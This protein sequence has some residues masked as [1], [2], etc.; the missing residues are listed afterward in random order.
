MKTIKMLS[1]AC[2]VVFALVAL[3]AT[4]ATA[5]EWRLKGAPLTKSVKFSQTATYTFKDLTIG[6]EFICEVEE[7]GTVGPG[8]AGQ[9]TSVKEVSCADKALCKTTPTIEAVRLPWNTELTTFEGGVGNHITSK[10]PEWKWKCEIVGFDIL[11]EYCEVAPTMK[12]T[13]LAEGDVEESIS[14][15]TTSCFNGPGRFHTHGGGLLFEMP[16]E[17]RLEVT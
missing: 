3:T 8:A 4:A 1:A 11:T 15:E 12:V 10:E 17:E 6:A 13:N 2:A 14:D 16:F 5:H 7:K 9:I